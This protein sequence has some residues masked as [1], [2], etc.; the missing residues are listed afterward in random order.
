MRQGG[1]ILSDLAL[2]A[3]HFVRSAPE[4]TIFVPIKVDRLTFYIM[5][6][7]LQQRAVQ[8]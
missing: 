3:T 7:L 2:Q 8:L 1:G 5:I 6:C 4:A